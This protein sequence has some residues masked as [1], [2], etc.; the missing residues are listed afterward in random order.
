MKYSTSMSESK[1][2]KLLSKKRKKKEGKML[3]PI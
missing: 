3:K 2:F 1:R